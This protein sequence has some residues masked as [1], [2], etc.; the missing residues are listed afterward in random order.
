MFEVCIKWSNQACLFFTELAGLDLAQTWNLEKE[1]QLNA[2][3]SA[4]AVAIAAAALRLFTSPA[5]FTVQ[6]LIIMAP[7]AMKIPDFFLAQIGIIM[8]GI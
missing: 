3:V 4:P 6:Q 2:A 5:S 8:V 1:K 7:E